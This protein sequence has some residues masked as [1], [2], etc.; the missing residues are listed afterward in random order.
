MKSPRSKILVLSLLALSLLLNVLVFVSLARS[1]GLRRI[2]LRMDLAEL[3]RTRQDFQ[4][5]MESRFLKF[6]NTPAE[7]VFVGDSQVAGGPWSEFFSEIHNRG[8]GG[9][10]AA[11]ILG[12]I[13]EVTESKPR[14]IFLLIGTNDLAASVPVVQLMR[15]YR[16]LLERIRKD[17][18]ETTVYVIGI[19]P[20]NPNMPLTP[21]QDNAQI[22]EANARIKR[23]VAEFPGTKY[24]DLSPFLSDEAGNLRRDFSTDGIHLNDDAYLAMREPLA[25]FVTEDEPRKPPEA[26]SKP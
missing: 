16:A 7:I 9:E 1:G 20:I 15:H 19:L 23:L 2:F 24:L 11:S 26:S 13:G 4:K 17:S 12:R 5:E 21:T 6:P 14:K 10:T 3:P 25:R 8:I 18:P 22:L